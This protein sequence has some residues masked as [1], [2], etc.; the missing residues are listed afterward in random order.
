MSEL[1][2]IIVPIYNVEKQVKKC[3]ESIIRQTYANIEIILVDDGSTDRSGAICDE[4]AAKDKRI[5]VIHKKNE[6][7]SDARNSGMEICSG[8]YVGFIDG[9]DWIA[10]DMYEF[11][12][13]TLVDNSVDISVCG[14]YMEDDEGVYASECADGNLKAYE[15]REAVCA[16]VK[17]EE[18]HSYAWNKLY[19]KEMFEGIRYPSKRYVQDIF[20]LYKV[21]MN[22][23]KIV[24]SNQPKYYYYQRKNSIQ[25]TRGNKL[26]WDQ[27]SAYCERIPVLEKGYPELREFLVLSA[28][29]FGVAAY[30]SLLLVPNWAEEDTMHANEMLET[31]KKYRQ[32][33]KDKHY[34]KR[35]DIIRTYFV[36]RK[37]YVR[38]YHALKKYC[39]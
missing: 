25:R 10:D 38:V 13:N 17:D 9:D 24:C 35:A 36:T 5:R 28:V 26:N 7:L 4:Y 1:I 21:F 33:I 27:F 6:G 30:N 39:F 11:L 32:E 18:I 34:G 3:I 14:Y 15:C 23:T 37:W 8:K 2:S 16:I 29:R 19:K 12:Y 20:V 31:I 22:A